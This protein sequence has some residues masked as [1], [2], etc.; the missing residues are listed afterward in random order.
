MQ[1]HPASELDYRTCLGS[2]KRRLS[3]TE[4]RDRLFTAV[5]G[6]LQPQKSK[7]HRARAQSRSEFWPLILYL[8]LLKGRD[9]TRTRPHVG[10]MQRQ[11]VPVV[12]L[13]TRSLST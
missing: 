2:L 10:R 5:L 6:K 1:Q 9:K 7:F 8:Q 13:P 11:L 3:K 12:A 4:R